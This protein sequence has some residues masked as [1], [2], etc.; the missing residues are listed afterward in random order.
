[1]H[2][3]FEFAPL[4]NSFVEVGD[5]TKVRFRISSKPYKKASPGGDAFLYGGNGGDRTHDK[6]LK[7]PLLYQLSYVPACQVLLQSSG[8]CLAE[9]PSTY[10]SNVTFIKIILIE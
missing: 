4:T 1:M 2:F 9:N 7:R 8:F 3:L 6:R 10:E 5:L